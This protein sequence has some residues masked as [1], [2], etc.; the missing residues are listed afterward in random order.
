MKRR[1]G[2]ALLFG[3]ILARSA[4]GQVEVACRLA[5]SR[6]LLFEPVRAAVRV[7][8]NTGH[9]LRFGGENPDVR[10][11]FSVE[12]APGEPVLPTG[13]PIPEA[14]LVLAPGET[15]EMEFNLLASYRIHATGP[16]TIQARVSQG[17]VAFVSPKAFLDVLP[18]FDVG[19]VA[20]GLAGA[21]KDTRLYTIKT[22]TRDRTELLFLRVDDEKSG[23]CLGVFDLG[24]IVRQFQ[25]RMESDYKGHIHVLHQSSPWKFTHPAVHPDAIPGA[26]RVFNAY[27]PGVRFERSPGGVVTLRGI[28]PPQDPSLFQPPATLT[29][30]PAGGK[31]R[32]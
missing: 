3:A 26:P 17:D 22:M 19:R 12:Q 5:A 11:G 20:V 18:G 29:P 16:Y 4:A 31:K 2:A 15:R 13:Q 1:L 14:P 27:D 8:N 25:P 30:D 23:R 7:T 28:R 9:P 24:R 32:R 21:A 10:L 6:T